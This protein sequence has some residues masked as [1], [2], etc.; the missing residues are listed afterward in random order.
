MLLRKLVSDLDIEYKSGNLDI[1]IKDVK[2]D[3]NSVTKGSLFI[4]LKGG[5]FD[6]HDYI[7]QVENYGAVAVI[8]QRK[9]QTSLVQIV[10]KDTRKAMSLIAGE[11]YNH[12]DRDL[13]MVGVLGTN[14][15]TTTAHLVSNILSNAGIKC[16]VIGTLGTFYNNKTIE[17]TLTTP[18]PF[19]LHKI[20][21]DMKDDGVEVVVME[22]SA[23]AVYFDK[24]YGIKFDYAIFTNFTQDHLDFFH[25][26]ESYKEAKL[27]FFKETRCK[28]V[29]TNSDDELGREISKISKNCIN[30]GIDNPADVFAIDI[31]NK[32]NKESFVINLFDKIYQVNLNLIGKFNIYNSMAAATCSA[33][34]GVKIEK[35]IEGLERIKSVSGRLEKIYDKNISIYIDYAHTPDGL[36]QSLKTLKTICKGRLISVFGCGGNRDKDKRSKMGKI[37][38]EIAD[39]TV[40]TS[41]NPRYEEPM[42]IIWEIERGIREATK[43]YV[44]VQDR[45]EGIEYAINYA[46][47]GDTVLIAGKGSEKYQEIFGIKHFYNDKD[48]VMEI[49]DKWKQ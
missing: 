19:E 37:S 49:M 46:K 40:I 43:K 3:S 45:T 9:V 15:K 32:G 1:E 14:G 22:V 4:C 38:G 24:V 41:D 28:Y 48:K 27:K 7:K 44:I 2:T 10:V 23:H 16:G 47:S 39:F 31:E 13:K 6:G 25:D 18:D 35:V 12:A 8:T 33:L 26:M 34:I 17:P 20:L 5:D 30:Y 11:F 21:K 42:D 29:I 36:Y